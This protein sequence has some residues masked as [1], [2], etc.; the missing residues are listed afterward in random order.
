MGGC[1]YAKKNAGNVCTENVLYMLK[2]I[3]VE[4]GVDLNK[5]KEIGKWMSQEIKRENLAL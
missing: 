2:E 5:V 4:T 3:G 1:P